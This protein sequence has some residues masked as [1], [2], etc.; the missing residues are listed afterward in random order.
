MMISILLLGIILTAAAMSL[1]QFG[2][3]AAEN[4]RRVQSTAIMN[5]LHEQFATASWYSLGLYDDEV[6]PLVDEG[7]IEPDGAGY[8]DEHGDPVVLLGDL[9]AAERDP[10][11]PDPSYTLEL[12]DRTY[13]VRQIVTWPDGGAA[14]V[15]RLKTIVSWSV[16]QRELTDSYS[17]ERAATASEV[18]DP[19]RPRVINF[20]AGP[21]LSSLN[22]S[23]RNLES[24][25][26]SV[27]F[28]Q[29]VDSAELRYYH[30][31]SGTPEDDPADEALVLGTTTL[32]ANVTIDEGKVGFTGEI[33]AEAHRFPD[34]IRI[35]RVVGQ[36][37]TEEARG[38][39][40]IAFEGGSIDPIPDPDADEIDPGEGEDVPD[41]GD[42][43]LEPPDRDVEITQVT[44]NTESVCLRANG[45]FDETLRVRARVAGLAEDDR[46]V[47]ATYTNATQTVTGEMSY[48]SS[49]ENESWFELELLEGTD[50]G[51]EPGNSTTFDIQA[52]RPQSDGQSDGP[53]ISLPVD[54]LGH[55]AAGC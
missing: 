4:E 20:L 36:A 48:K 38:Y 8:V 10:N 9:G 25:T 35:L 55:K 31:A 44:L 45:R 52:S 37:G 11:V 24:I 14:E 47:T 15:K 42:G 16:F 12:D 41:T 3:T 30:L 7:L 53:V 5:G 32:T 39:T 23:D 13:E 22:S 6:Q 17:S 54:F 2:R 27:R 28:S 26:V 46:N 21:K 19:T 50:Y 29:P 1:I 18:G 43:D 40:T 34:G 49:T 33:P 51:F